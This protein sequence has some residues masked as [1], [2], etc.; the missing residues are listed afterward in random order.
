MRPTT[1][2]IRQAASISPAMEEKMLELYPEAFG[3]T[4]IN[5]ISAGHTCAKSIKANLVYVLEKLMNIDV[6]KN[7]PGGTYPQKAEAIA[8]LIWETWG[9]G[10]TEIPDRLKTL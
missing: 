7:I 5:Q 4:A 10:E 8:Q 3:K 2:D 1:Q 6:Q 9:D